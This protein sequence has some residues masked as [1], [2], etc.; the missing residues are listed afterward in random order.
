MGLD[1]YLTKQVYV[2]NWSHMKPPEKH[3]I[4]IKKGGKVRA[5]IDTKAIAYVVEEVCTWRK[6]NAIHQWFVENCQNGNDDCNQ[7]RVSSEQL[8]K[9]RDICKEV[10]ADMSKAPKLLP[11][12]EGFFFGGVEY[13]RWY[14][15]DL[16]ITVKTLDKA[17][18]NAN[19]E[20]YYQSSW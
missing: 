10:L 4:T 15:D 14:F 13:D 16:E 7:H 3:K 11:T 6:S 1:M 9:L 12:Q 18:Q 2:K 8:E 19:G 5:D 20:F 17:L